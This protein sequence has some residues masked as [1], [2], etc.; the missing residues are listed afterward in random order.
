MV[1]TNG[2]L[3]VGSDTRTSIIGILVNYGAGTCSLYNYLTATGATFGISTLIAAGPLFLMAGL[4]SSGNAVSLNSTGPFFNLPSGAAAWGASTWNPADAAG[5]IVFSAGNTIVAGSGA[6]WQGVRSVTSTTTGTVYAEINVEVC[7]NNFGIVLGLATSAATLT[8][9]GASAAISGGVDC[10]NDAFGQFP[11]PIGLWQPPGTE[12][13]VG[14]PAGYR[15]RQVRSTRSILAPTDKVVWETTLL[16]NIAGAGGL[17]AGF[18]TAA[19]S[20]N[21]LPFIGPAEGAY[22]GHNNQGIG[23]QFN[24]DAV[25]ENGSFV[26]GSGNPTVGDTL[27]HAVS[28]T[29]GKYWVRNSATGLWMN[30]IL[31]NQNPATNTGGVSITYIPGGS[32]LFAAVSVAG[33]QALDNIATA[34]FGASPFVNPTPAGYAAFNSVAT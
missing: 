24:A 18:S 12:A 25:L 2:N 21:S 31:A 22:P 30:D 10:I 16:A 5:G 23:A 27:M 32:A 20:L 4:Y 15:W 7:T 14:Q 33:V 6:A 28:L 26:P 11:T 17:I 8:Y 3:T 19:D 13:G 1:L 29:W 9:P 34:N